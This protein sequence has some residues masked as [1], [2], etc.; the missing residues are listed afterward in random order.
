MRYLNPGCNS[1]LDYY[2]SAQS[3]DEAF[4]TKF[5]T[6]RSIVLKRTQAHIQSGGASEFWFS[7]DYILDR[8]QHGG[9]ILSLSLLDEERKEVVSVG[10]T[11]EYSGLSLTINVKNNVVYVVPKSIE[12]STVP[13]NIEFHVKLGAEGRIDIW[14]DTK[15]LASYRSPT[16]FKDLRVA[17]VGVRASG[18]AYGSPP[19]Y[20]S[21][22]ILQDTRRVGLEKF[23][24]LAVS[25]G[26]E[27]SMPQGSST[28]YTVSGLD[29]STEFSDITSFGVLLQPTS[30]DANITTGSF[31]LGGASV[32]TVDVSSSSGK[33]YA[34][35]VAPTC[36]LTGRPFT[37]ADINGKQLVLTVNGA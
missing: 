17:Y 35:A 15:L 33:D 22:L 36:S 12:A 9:E 7:Y 10:S 8:G 31:T 23:K 28:T 11:D 34:L 19:L 30:R 32:G 24:M 3:A 37:R 6:K 25:P 27:Q 18:N 5:S 13:V 14:T 2:T 4:N 16:V 26:G 20:I 1:L 29:D 21:S